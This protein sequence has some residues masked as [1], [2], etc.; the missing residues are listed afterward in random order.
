LL[1]TTSGRYRADTLLNKIP[2]TDSYSIKAKYD[3]FI[4]RLSLDNLVDL[5]NRWA[6]FGALSDNELKFIQNAATTLR[7]WLNDTEWQAELNR[8]INK[9]KLWKI[10]SNSSEISS[11]WWLIYEFQNYNSSGWWTTAIDNYQSIL[12]R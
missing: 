10:N 1:N 7:L 2:W 8:I 3:W 11:W 9:L 5:K 4:S 6:T 12:N